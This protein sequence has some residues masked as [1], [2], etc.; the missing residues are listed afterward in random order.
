[1]KLSAWTPWLSPMRWWAW[2][3]R[4]HFAAKCSSVLGPL[5]I[6]GW[7]DLSN[8]GRLVVGRHVTILSQLHKVSLGVY[9]GATLV[10]GDHV[11]INNGTIIS[12][13]ERVEL[14]EGCALGYHVL[15]MDSDQHP[16][17][18]GEPAK[19][20]P[21]I[22]GRHVW[23]GSKATL[24][25][26]VQVGDHAVIAAGAVVTKDVPA[27]AVVAGVPARVVRMLDPEAVHGPRNPHL[28]LGPEGRPDEG[29]AQGDGLSVGWDRG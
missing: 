19:C 5:E 22:L 17:V 29:E 8:D 24:L 13:K 3:K 12:A 1:M 28:R 20:A 14:G 11:F 6:V 2:A 10:L 27:Y 25:R 9:P 26:G 7:P 15:V 18:P 21:V 4:R 16:V 23:V